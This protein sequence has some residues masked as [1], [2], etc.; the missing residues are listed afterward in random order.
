MNDRR[1]KEYALNIFN[2]VS[3]YSLQK[4]FDLF[5]KYYP[6]IAFYYSELITKKQ[7]EL[8]ARTIQSVGITRAQTLV[9]LVRETKFPIQKFYFDSISTMQLW[10]EKTEYFT[11]YKDTDFNNYVLSAQKIHAIKVHKHIIDNAKSIVRL[12]N[13]AID[14]VIDEAKKYGYGNI[15]DEAKYYL[16][17]N[18][19]VLRDL[20]E[21]SKYYTERLMNYELKRIILED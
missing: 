14:K 19:N 3:G 6:K 17:I 5:P 16:A 12:N 11:K 7:E 1:L 8:T 9:K 2:N 10:D 4:A 13:K 15:L 20:L 18:E 21:A